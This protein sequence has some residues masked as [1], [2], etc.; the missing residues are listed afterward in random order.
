[1]HSRLTLIERA[2]HHLASVRSLTEQKLS[3][4]FKNLKAEY[5]YKTDKHANDD[6]LESICEIRNQK[7]KLKKGKAC[8]DW[9]TIQKYPES[10]F[11]PYGKNSFLLKKENSLWIFHHEGLNNLLHQREGLGSSGEIY[12][13]GKDHLIKSASRFLTK[14]ENVK[15]NNLSVEKGLEKQK[16]VEVVDDYRNIKV[17]SAYTHFHFDQLEFVLLSEI[18]WDEVTLPLKELLSNLLIIG[19][20]I[21]TLSLIIAL[22]LTRSTLR[23]VSRIEEEIISLNSQSTINVL[24][25]Q[26]EERQKIAYNLHDSVGQY[27]TALKWELSRLQIES[28]EVVAKDKLEKLLNLADTI[29]KE[30]RIISQNIMPSIIKD[31]GCF[32]AIKD[33]FYQQIEVYPFSIQCEYPEE[34]EKINFKQSFQINLFRMAQEFT[35]NAAKHAQAQNLK[36]SFSKTEDSLIMIYEDNGIGMDEKGPLPHSLLY[37]A[38]LFGGRM[39]R[40]HSEK[41]LK[42][43]VVFKLSEIV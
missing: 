13:V 15:V 9:K 1:M 41:G 18:D 19:L 14:W 31:F 12:L 6:T 40:I 25:A 20:L 7:V 30:I 34:I 21:F 28:K 17:V 32:A 37:R 27:L 24:R 3:L 33:Y 39:N 38:K 2:N 26:E 42:I 11:I 23:F 8:P 4:Y 43:K 29:I 22:F 36:L 35:Q 10:T 5:L 16:G